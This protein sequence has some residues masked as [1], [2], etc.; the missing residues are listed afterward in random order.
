[1]KGGGKTVSL[2]NINQR[3]IY[4][5]ALLVV[6][7]PLMKP[8]GLPLTIS[9]QVQQA[10]DVLVSV[11]EGGVVLVSFDIEPNVAELIPQA[12][13]ILNILEERNIRV[14]TFTS[15]AESPQLP[16]TATAETYG[17]AG[18]EYGVDYVNLGYYAGLEASLAAFCENVRDVFKTDYSGNSLDSLPLMK[19]I[20]GIKDFDLA[21]TVNAS[22]GKGTTIEMWVRQANIAYKKPL[23]VGTMGVSGPAAMSYLQSKNIDGLMI[24]LKS[25]AELEQ[26]GNK[27]GR[28]SSAMD[29]LTM[30]DLMIVVLLIL[31]NIGYLAGRRKPND[32]KVSA[33]GAAQ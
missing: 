30:A 13:A 16:E 5:L 14:V 20:N 17:A 31:G 28:A 8:I 3:F 29:A 21:V 25:A 1:M 22:A 7:V 11:P 32:G 26:L 12:K 23:L 2:A 10:Y 6:V 9:A 33:G 4:L 15:Y 19:D 24:G 27:I 18:K